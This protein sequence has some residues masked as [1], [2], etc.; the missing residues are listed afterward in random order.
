MSKRR[1]QASEESCSL[2]AVASLRMLSFSRKAGL[3]RA[4]YTW[5]T[6]PEPTGS[7]FSKQRTLPQSSPKACR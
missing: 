2:E 4:L 5:A 3:A 1:G 7:C 6:Q